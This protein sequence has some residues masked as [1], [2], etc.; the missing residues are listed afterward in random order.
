MGSS[1][2]LGRGADTVWARR[3]GVLSQVSKCGGSPPLDEDLSVGTPDLGHPAFVQPHPGRK[4]NGAAR[5]GH[6][7]LP[8]DP[9]KINPFV[10]TGDFGIDY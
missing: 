9:W 10:S 6:P 4:N 1:R 5:V 7:Y 3:P 2:E 8:V